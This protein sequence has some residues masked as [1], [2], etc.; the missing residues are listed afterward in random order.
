M[1]NLVFRQPLQLKRGSYN[2]YMRYNAVAGKRAVGFR[3]S[4]KDYDVEVLVNCENHS[5][6]RF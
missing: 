4:V 6:D 3:I 5:D 1:A 2:H